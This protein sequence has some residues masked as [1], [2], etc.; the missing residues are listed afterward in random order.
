MSLLTLTHTSGGGYGYQ[1]QV[2]A[3]DEQVDDEQGA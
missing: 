2:H 1:E 3:D